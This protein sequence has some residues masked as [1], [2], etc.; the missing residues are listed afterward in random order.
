M[1]RLLLCKLIGLVLV[2]LAGCARS[3]SGREADTASSLDVASTAAALSTVEGAA[4]LNPAA[5]PLVPV[6][7]IASRYLDKRPCLERRSG[8]AVLSGVGFGA[9]GNNVLVM[10]GA[11]FPPLGLLLGIP[12]YQKMMVKPCVSALS[13]AHVLLLARWRYAYQTGDVA[14]LRRISGNEALLAAY[15]DLFVRTVSRK[16]AYTE[17]ESTEDGFF[18]TYDV[19][20]VYV[21]GSVE[22]FRGIL[23]FEVEAGRI[24]QVVLL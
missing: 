12:F 8:H 14:E 13:D 20:M 16:V 2:L 1:K 4:E 11:A 9:M 18:A 19:T 17:L 3:E 7:F 21:D 22:R 24:A 23:Q 6:R 10:S 15:A 5:L